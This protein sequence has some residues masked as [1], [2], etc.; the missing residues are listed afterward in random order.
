MSLKFQYVSVTSTTHP[1]G[2]LEEYITAED[3][4]L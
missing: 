2:D 1:I 4:M 3:A